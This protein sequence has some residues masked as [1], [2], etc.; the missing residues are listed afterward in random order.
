MKISAGVVEIK[1][2]VKSL[3]LMY[4]NLSRDIEEVKKEQQDFSSKHEDM[5]ATVNVLER[6]IALLEK[7]SRARNLLIFN[8]DDV[9]EINRDLYLSIARIFEK[10]KVEI[11]DQAIESIFRLGKVVGR[12][13]VLVRFASPRWK[14][15][16]FIKV[17]ELNELGLTIANDLTEDE[18]KE[19]KSL[20]MYLFSLKK[21]GHEAKLKGNAIII[22]NKAYSLKDLQESGESFN[23]SEDVDTEHEREK[24]II[25]TQNKNVTPG[26]KRK[27]KDYTSGGTVKPKR[28][29]PIG[30]FKLTPSRDTK[31]L[32][33]FF[34]QRKKEELRCPLQVKNS[35]SKYLRIT[36][37]KSQ[38]FYPHDVSALRGLKFRIIFWNTHGYANIEDLKSQLHQHD[39]L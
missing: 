14:S 18:R 8:L 28:G 31:P 3:K 6:R 36:E 17:K 21:Q 27:L 11:P 24:S 13:P 16:L 10:I 7:N 33:Q 2:E 4:S 32:T 35:S 15:L 20:L 9:E 34:I 38:L 1:E 37:I 23:P 39:I 29:R 5:C 19:R 22:K 12:R 30:S 26:I 25:V